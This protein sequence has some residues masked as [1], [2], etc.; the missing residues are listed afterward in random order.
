MA[1]FRCNRCNCVYEDYYPPDDTCTKC[2]KGR[3]RIV[4]LKLRK[5]LNLF[6]YMSDF[7][8]LFAYQATDI[9]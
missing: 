3:I 9:S 4:N 7:P 6:V 5:P 2:K 1:R 8:N